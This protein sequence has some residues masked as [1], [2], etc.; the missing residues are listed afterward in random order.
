MPSL[1]CCAF[2]WLGA[3]KERRASWVVGKEEIKEEL[4]FVVGRVAKHEKNDA[5]ECIDGGK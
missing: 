1:F 5:R 4:D 2:V 3:A